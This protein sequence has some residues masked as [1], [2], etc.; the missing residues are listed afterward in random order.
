M[1][2]NFKKL[3][4]ILAGVLESETASKIYLTVYRKGGLKSKDIARLT[5]LHPSTVRNC[6]YELCKQKVLHRKKNKEAKVGKN[7]YV[8]FAAPPDVL[9]KRYIKRLESELDQLA[10]LAGAKIEIRFEEERKC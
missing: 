10:R 4:K 9:I 2:I 7:P 8:Y 5:K 1:E 6:L 3:E